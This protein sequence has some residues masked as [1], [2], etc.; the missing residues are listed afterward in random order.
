MPPYMGCVH[1]CVLV[2]N[3]VLLTGISCLHIHVYEYLSTLLGVIII[4]T[5][6]SV[7]MHALDISIHYLQL[8]NG[9]ANQKATACLA[10]VA[11]CPGGL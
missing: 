10:H 8:I 6:K 3:H 11:Y 4:I 9:G 5:R 2:Y 1:V 7:S